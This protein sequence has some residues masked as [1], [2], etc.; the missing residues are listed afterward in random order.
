MNMSK[1]T[2]CALREDLILA[3]VENITLGKLF[4]NPDESTL[5]GMNVA[6]ILEDNTKIIEAIEAEL[7][8]RKEDE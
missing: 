8:R 2:T 4:P 7:K 3:K 5:K 6:L 1:F